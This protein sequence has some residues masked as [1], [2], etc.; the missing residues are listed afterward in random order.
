MVFMAYQPVASPPSSPAR[1]LNG[2]EA[3]R[4][5][6]N[7][8]EFVGSVVAAPATAILNAKRVLPDVIGS[9]DEL[10]PINKATIRAVGPKYSHSNN[11]VRE[12]FLPPAN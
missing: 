8:G 6:G 4:I 7:E 1:V 2:R 11:P 5:A 9:T 3:D 12:S 10:F